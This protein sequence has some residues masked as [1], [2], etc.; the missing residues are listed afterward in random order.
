METVMNEEFQNIL[1]Y[2]NANKLS[3]NMQKNNFM[4]ICPPQKLLPLNIKIL[5]IEQKSTLNT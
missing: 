3:I 2:C 1:K 5:N 4:L